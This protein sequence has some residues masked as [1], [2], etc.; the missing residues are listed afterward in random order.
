MGE[1]SGDGVPALQDKKVLEGFHP[2]VHCSAQL[3]CA[4]RRS[5]DGIL[6]SVCSAPV[7]KSPDVDRWLAGGADGVVGTPLPVLALHKIRD[8][9][10]VQGRV[11]AEH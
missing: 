10:L 4:L 6:Y 1:F 3:S 5:Q 8:S 11:S 2:S 9:E 7:V